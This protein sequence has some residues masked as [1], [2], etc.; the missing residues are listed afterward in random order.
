ML[1]TIDGEKVKKSLAAAGEPSYKVTASHVLDV[2]PTRVPPP[3]SSIGGTMMLGASVASSDTREYVLSL[4][5]KIETSGVS[6]K[7][8]DELSKEIDEMRGR[9]R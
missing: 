4:R 9:S 6:L 8:T 7:S 1:L 2:E 5:R 3:S